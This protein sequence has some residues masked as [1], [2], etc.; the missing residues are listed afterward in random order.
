MKPTI[1]ESEQVA[2][3]SLKARLTFIGLI[4]QA[5]DDGR[6]KGSPRRIKGQ[7]FRYDD[8]TAEE[9]NELLTELAVNELIIRFENGGKQFIELPT[10]HQHQK[11]NRKTDSVLPSHSDPDS[12]ITHGA[13]TEDSLQEGRGTEGNKEGKGKE[14]SGLAPADANLSHLLADLVAANDPNGKRPNVTKAWAI[15]EDRMLRLDNRN[16]EEARRLIEWTQ[17]NSFWRGNVRSMKTFRDKYGQLYAAAVDEA[18]KKKQKSGQSGMD[19]A[20]RLA[21]RAARREA[22]RKQ[23]A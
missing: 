4:T 6:L 3:V 10:W 17:S 22:E 18:T 13:L 9:V 16:P 5:D 11:I 20:H 21:E 8:T 23:A 14:S 15:E 7:L 12:V 19:N 2:E 1:W